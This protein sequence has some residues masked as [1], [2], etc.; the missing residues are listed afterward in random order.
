ML[1][2]SAYAGREVCY[3]SRWRWLD[4]RSTQRQFAAGR[5]GVAA[6]GIRDGHGLGPFADARFS[7]RHYGWTATSC[8]Y[9][10]APFPELGGRS[11]RFRIR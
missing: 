11:F 4:H 10:P 3:R 7:A 2:L 8:L 5:C 6:I 1:Q 9:P